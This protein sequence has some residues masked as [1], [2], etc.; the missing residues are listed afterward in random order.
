MKT[1]EDP[2]K[3]PTNNPG[4]DWK[5]KKGEKI[6]HKGACLTYSPRGSPKWMFHIEYNNIADWFILSAWDDIDSLIPLHIWLFHKNDMVRIGKGDNTPKVEFWKRK[7]IA[8]INT[9]KGI[10]R[11]EK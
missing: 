6:D 7:S 9:P 2:I 1:F 10:K 3:M 4:F 8:I 5:C 11:F